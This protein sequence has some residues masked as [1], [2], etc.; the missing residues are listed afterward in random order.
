MIFTSN[1]Q[2][3]FEKN[4]WQCSM[5]VN[6]TVPLRFFSFCFFLI[7]V[8]TFHLHF[9][10]WKEGKNRTF[11]NYRSQTI[12]IEY[13]KFF[14]LYKVKFSGIS[15][16][17]FLDQVVHCRF[18]SQASCCLGFHYRKYFCQHGVLF[19]LLFLLFLL[20]LSLNWSVGTRVDGLKGLSP[21]ILSY[22]DHQKNSF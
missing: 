11:K 18:A 22:F 6:A 20:L 2:I 10:F 7:R 15:W 17:I 12:G 1:S 3:L 8:T 9:N 21:G 13:F 16:Q 5:Q 19:S 4:F 14:C